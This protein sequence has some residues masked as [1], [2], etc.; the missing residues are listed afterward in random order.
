[1]Y[2]RNLPEAYVN[3]LGQVNLDELHIQQA[4]DYYQSQFQKSEAAKEFVE[5][6]CTIDDDLRGSTIVGFCDR[7]MG[8]NILRTKTAEGA[9][10]RGSLIRVGLIKA[11]GHELFSGYVVFP[12][13]HDNGT[14]ISAV[15]YRIGRI[16]PGDKAV[17]YWHR[18][19]PKAFVDVA[20]SYA[21]ELLH[22]QAYH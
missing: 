3:V 13:Y 15:G 1:M 10:I 6:C 19:E 8:R 5:R 9:A 7:T 17:I 2:I 14:V 11:T 4:F 18:P 21:K 22:G 20:M 16:R 12:T